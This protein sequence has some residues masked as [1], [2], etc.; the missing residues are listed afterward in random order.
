MVEKFLEKL[1]GAVGNLEIDV[2]KS[3][4]F[5]DEDE[6]S[7]AYEDTKDLFFQKYELLVSEVKTIFGEPSFDNGMAAKGFPSWYE[8]DFM[9]LWPVADGGG[10]YVALCQ[11]DKELPFMLVIGVRQAANNSL[12]GR[13]P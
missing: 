10:V 7:S 1:M 6:F 9:A 11:H 5:Y 13:R 8:A 2:E 3:Q 12:Q 4:D